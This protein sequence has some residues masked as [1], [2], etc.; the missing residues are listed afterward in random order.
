MAD[1]DPA[2]T[3]YKVLGTHVL[4]R[5][6]A[7]GWQALAITSPTQGNGKTCTA[8]NLAVSLVRD[9]K[10]TVLLVDLDQ[11]RSTV[12]SC[13]FDQPVV[14]LSD[15]FARCLILQVPIDYPRM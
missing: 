4:Q 14:S 5:M 8:I 7:N 1:H 2:A 6:R 12:A 9:P 10:H 13:F 15:D 11:C 3:A